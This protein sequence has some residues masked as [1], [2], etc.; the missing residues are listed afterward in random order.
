VRSFAV[1][2]PR[3]PRVVAA[4][5]LGAAITAAGLVALFANG[6]AAR[7]PFSTYAS[8]YRTQRTALTLLPIAA[9]AG[10]TRHKPRRAHLARAKKPETV[11]ALPH[12]D[13]VCVR[14]CDGYFFPL[15]AAAGDAASQAASCDS[16]CPDAPT[17]V[18]YRR[19]SD[20][21]EDSVSAAGRP[22]SALPVALRYRSTA[23]S[24][25]SCHRD[26]IAYAPLYD[27]T[28]QRGDL[29]MTPAGFVMFRGPEG[30]THGAGDFIALAKARLP[31]AMR[32]DLQA[33][34]RASLATDHPT[35]REWFA[36]QTPPTLVARQ[37][38]RRPERRIERVVTRV[39]SGDDRIRLLVWRGGAQD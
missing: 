6:A 26:A 15:P 29:I 21:I 31:S 12:P 28:L 14:L 37:I 16:L 20:R 10:K 18:Y 38:E 35:L 33:M 34:E 11:A 4:F 19:G 7:G 24:T 25:C 23:D 8:Y 13:A 32:G 17:Q 36:S 3:R 39:A 22:Y 9:N 1:E 30:P 27:T 5:G 2:A